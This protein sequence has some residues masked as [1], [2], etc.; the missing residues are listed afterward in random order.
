MSE[1]GATFLPKNK[2]NFPLNMFKYVQWYG[3]KEK[4]L[5]KKNKK[6]KSIKV[7]TSL[8]KNN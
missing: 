1:F 8:Y 3:V 4:N 5:N 6:E 2:Y 7:E